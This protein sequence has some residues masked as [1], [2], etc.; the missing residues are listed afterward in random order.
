MLRLICIRV[1]FFFSIIFFFFLL[2]CRSRKNVALSSSDKLI[3]EKYSQLLSVNST[4]IESNLSLFRFV[5][6][7]IGVPYL[8]G[9]KDKKG[10]D[11]SAF[12]AR[13]LKDNFNLSATGSANDMF[14]KSRKIQNDKVQLG[15]LVFFKI[16][17][18]KISHVGVFLM[19]NKF[20]H[21]SSSKGVVI[22]NLDEN[23]YKKYFVGFGAL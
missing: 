1:C 10:I 17:S 12:V 20:I 11:C 2:S 9:G 15:N 21:A 23:Y 8:F 4:Q 16:E 7:W 13:F 22:S 6:E 18:K 19:N 14:E 3:I 5:N